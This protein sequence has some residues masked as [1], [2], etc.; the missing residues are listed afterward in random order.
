M[1]RK[2]SLIKRLLPLLAIVVLLALAA[3]SGAATTTAPGATTSTSSVTTTSS[4]TTTTP[5]STTPAPPPGTGA[6]SP[7]WV[8]PV[9][10]TANLPQDFSAVVA[11]VR[12]S[13]VAINVE[14]T[15]YNI[16]N[17]PVTQQGAGSGWIIDPSGL[18]VT[19]AHVVEGAQDIT[20]SLDDGRSLPATQVAADSVSD[21]AVVKINAS[22]L[23]AAAIG[24]ST[25]MKV[26]MSV[27]A[28]GN[29]LGQ[30]ISM[31]GGWISRLGASIT[32]N[33]ETLYDLIETDAA[34]NPGN[35]GG[36]LINTAGQVIGITN[37]KLVATGVEAIGYAIS[38]ATA[39]PIIQQLVDQGYVTRPWFGVS[40]QTVSSG[41]AF[42]YNL[43]VSQGALITSVVS[44]GPADKAGL[45]AGDVIVGI[46]GQDI[47]SSADAQQAILSS[48]IGQPVEVKYW[49]GNSQQ[50]VQVTPATM[51]PP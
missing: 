5:T 26:G 10:E 21:L 41:I 14:L 29:A 36:P 16:F 43:S 38:T 46:G 27:A 25:Q 28:I 33:N 40:L 4:A 42:I 24:D 34:I 9:V 23:T 51:P 17:Q 20:V 39:M 48:Q 35:S 18:I 19:N 13:V 37:A 30:G 15:S 3:C 47:T 8:V 31:T 6:I 45:K 12:P 50:T 1:Q 11:K 32:V 22:G 2:T 44:G 7:G 49:R